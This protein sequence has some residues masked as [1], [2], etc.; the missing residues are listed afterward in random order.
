MKKYEIPSNSTIFGV[1]TAR[2]HTGFTLSNILDEPIFEVFELYNAAVEIAKREKKEIDKA[3]NK[4]STNSSADPY[5]VE[6][7][8]E[9][10][11]NYEELR[12]EVNY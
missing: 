8:F 5:A 4:N 6:D 12:K 7:S 1:I 10:L 2:F 11:Q 3:K 9:E